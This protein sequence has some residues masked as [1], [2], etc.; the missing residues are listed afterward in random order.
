MAGVIIPSQ[1]FCSQVIRVH[2]VP[3]QPWQVCVS[4]NPKREQKQKNDRWNPP[5]RLDASYDT[6]VY[7]GKLLERRTICRGNDDAPK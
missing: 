2:R 1:Y 5:I 7:V 6:L 4:E 3:I